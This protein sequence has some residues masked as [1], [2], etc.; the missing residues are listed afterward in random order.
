MLKPG[1]KGPFG[2]RRNAG[3]SIKRIQ[4][5]VVKETKGER[6]SGM[7]N[8]DMD[9]EATGIGSGPPFRRNMEWHAFKEAQ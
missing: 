2:L 9:R 6:P 8:P 3:R 4:L 7:S 1:D 5:S